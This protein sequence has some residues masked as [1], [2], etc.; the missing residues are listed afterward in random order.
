MRNSPISKL[1]DHQRP[2]DST[3]LR[4]G[5]FKGE[6]F[7]VEFTHSRPKRRITLE[8]PPPKPKM[9]A[10]AKDYAGMRNGRMTAFFWFRESPSKTSSIWVVKCD[11]G[12]Y[13]FRKKIGRWIKGYKDG[14]DMCE[15]CE[16]EREMLTGRT[17]KEN[18]GKRRLRFIE[19]MRTKGL[20]DNDIERLMRL[21]VGLETAKT[22]SEI[23]DAIDAKE[24]SLKE[25][26]ERQH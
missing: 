21:G 22:K 18:E 7:E 4:V 17:S 6:N 8:N 5:F 11:C 3:A 13:E 1:K 25:Y 10:T 9:P 12:R 14:N 16:R 26:Q 19:K 2:A 23:L 24:A 15:I 20:Q